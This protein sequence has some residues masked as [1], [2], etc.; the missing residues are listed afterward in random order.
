MKLLPASGIQA[1]AVAF[2]ADISS[3]NW[4]SLPGYLAP[5]ATW[6]VQGNAALEDNVGTTTAAAHLPALSQLADLFT[7]YSY[8]VTTVVASPGGSGGFSGSV[9]GRWGEGGVVM[10][11][12]QAVGR[13]PLDLLYVNNISMSF[14]FD[15]QNK[16]ESVREYP[17]RVEINWLLG[18][19]QAHNVT[20][21]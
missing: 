17:D 9:G 21:G 13:G 2:V 4:T 18:W 3:R 20:S 1:I 12:A 14:G 15:G 6:W 5:N 16:I 19:L 7:T 10:L 8:D 11:E